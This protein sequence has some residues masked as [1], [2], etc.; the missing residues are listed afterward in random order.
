[1]FFGE[2]YITE[3]SFEYTYCG[4]SLGKYIYFLLFSSKYDKGYKSIE[5]LLVKTENK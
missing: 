4:S 3:I 5:Y 2:F 1:M